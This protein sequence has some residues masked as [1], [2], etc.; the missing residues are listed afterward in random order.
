MCFADIVSL[1][2]WAQ[3]VRDHRLQPSSDLLDID[4]LIQGSGANVTTREQTRQ[5]N[6]RRY[7]LHRVTLDGHI[8]FPA[9]LSQD[10]SDARRLAYRHM[11]DV[12]THEPGVR[13]KVSTAGRVKV[14]K[15]P[16]RDAPLD[17]K[18]L[19]RSVGR[20]L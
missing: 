12:C 20:L 8:E 17:G 2:K 11:L 5:S 6:G 18:H 1:S 14:N 4:R 13:M 9:G 3:V 7:F 16:K 10:P 15:R 19:L